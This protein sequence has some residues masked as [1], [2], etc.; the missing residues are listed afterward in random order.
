M[1]MLKVT[2]EPSGWAAQFVSGL[3]VVHCV[4]GRDPEVCR[5]LASG[6]ATARGDPG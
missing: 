5:R 4:G 2:H 1:M 3:T 6:F